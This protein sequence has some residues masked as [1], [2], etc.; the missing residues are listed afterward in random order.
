MI[1]STVVQAHKNPSFVN[2]NIRMVKKNVGKNVICVIDSANWG[3]FKDEQMECETLCGY[4]HNDRRNP[5]KNFANGLSQLYRRFPDSEWFCNSEF[6]VFFKN[7][8]FKEDLNRFRKEHN[9]GL[10]GFNMRIKPFDCPFINAMLKIKFDVGYY[11]IGCCMFFH[12]SYMERL[13]EVNFFE[14]FLNYT[15]S[16]T[17]SN[18]PCEEYDISEH[19]YPSLAANIGIPIASFENAESSVFGKRKYFVRF[20]PEVTKDVVYNDAYSIIHPYK[21][22]M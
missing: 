13:I 16:F 18:I 20:K 9:A 22:A 7:D 14:R 2:E 10:V 3:E 5:Y 21:N 17:S 4:Y 15:S 6:D 19:L 8:S 12:R 1:I 11:M